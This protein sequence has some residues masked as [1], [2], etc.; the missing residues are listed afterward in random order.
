MEQLWQEIMA[1]VPTVHD[2]LNVVFRLFLAALVGAVPGLQREQ[3]G[4]PAGLRTHMLVSIGAAIFMMAALEADA[5]ID[6]TTR[7]IQG[8]A[9][10]IGFVGAGAILKYKEGT[11]IRGL[12]TA[13]SVWLTAAL[14]TAVGAG[15]IW[16]PIVG[17]VTAFLVLSL[18]RRVEAVMGDRHKQP[19]AER[20]PPAR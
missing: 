20:N 8:L 10:G 11:E 4:M 19:E 16:L 18:F 17:G 3:L 7:V 12:T 2:A 5:S 14:G 6:A 1:E 13:A 15:R 9:T